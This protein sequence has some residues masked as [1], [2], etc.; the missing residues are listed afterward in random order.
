[1]GGATFLDVSVS[2]FADVTNW[3]LLLTT[4]DLGG[5]GNVA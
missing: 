3:G 1:M 5:D 4:I 2:Y